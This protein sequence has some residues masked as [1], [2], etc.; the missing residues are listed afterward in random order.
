VHSQE[1]FQIHFGILHHL[2]LL[3]LHSKN[4]DHGFVQ[5]VSLKLNIWLLLVLVLVAVRLVEEEELV[6][7]EQAR[8]YQSQQAIHIQL[9]LG[10]VVLV[11]LVL[12]AMELIQFFQQLLQLV[13]AVVVL[14]Q[15]LEV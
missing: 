6:G 11:V 8:D 7:F 14:F 10:L 12:A 5:Q 4:L 3:L 2:E 9:Q 13:V 15:V 1:Q